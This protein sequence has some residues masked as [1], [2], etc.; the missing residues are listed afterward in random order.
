MNLNVLQTNT[1]K[2]FQKNL[3]NLEVLILKCEKNSFILAPELCLSGYSYEDMNK[4][5]SFTPKAIK[6]LLDLSIEKTIS[7]TLLEKKDNKFF[8][9]LYLFSNNKILHTQSKYK[10]FILNKEDEYFEKGQKEEIKIFEANGLKVA[11]L[12][13]F[14]LRFIELWEQIKGADVILLP[15]LWGEK[16]K[17]NYETLSKALAVANQCYVM[18]SSS[19]SLGAAKSSA[20]ISPSGEV[21]LDDTQEL[22]SKSFDKNEIRKMRKSLYVGIS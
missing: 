21:L 16:R 14:E 3:D 5:A 7:L 1:L 13:C 15:A 2:D 8:N 9:T 20:I 11:A 10:L 18:A 19:A 6:K 4:A 22:L 17:D 12:I